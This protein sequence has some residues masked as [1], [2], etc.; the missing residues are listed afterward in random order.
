MKPSTGSTV[1]WT[2]HGTERQGRVEG[3]DKNGLLIVRRGGVPWH[4]DAGSVRV[5]DVSDAAVVKGL[6][7]LLSA[8]AR[9]R[10]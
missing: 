3:Y 1:S 10:A 6:V 4:L 8:K 2:T 7:N 5:V 9:G